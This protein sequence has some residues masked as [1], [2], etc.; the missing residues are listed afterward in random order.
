MKQ[1]CFDAGFEKF[2]LSRTFFVLLNHGDNNPL[3][4]VYYIHSIEEYVD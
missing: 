4:I 3:K 2:H 1:S